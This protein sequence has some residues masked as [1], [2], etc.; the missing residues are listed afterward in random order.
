TMTA[1]MSESQRQVF[2]ARATAISSLQNAGAS[3]TPTADT[4][5]KG[6]HGMTKAEIEAKANELLPTK[7][8]PTAK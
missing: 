8:H 7:V 4:M 2:M 3:A 5:W 6:I 1:D